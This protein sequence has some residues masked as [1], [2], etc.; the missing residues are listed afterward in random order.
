MLAVLASQYARGLVKPVIDEVLPLSRLPEAY[1]RLAG[2]RVHGKLV[3]VP[4]GLMT[5]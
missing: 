2:R 3:L 1:A 5:A 4:D